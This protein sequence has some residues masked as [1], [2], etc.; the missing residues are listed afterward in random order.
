MS[1]L[2][3]LR[4]VLNMIIIQDFPRGEEKKRRGKVCGSHELVPS[5]PRKLE[6]A[7]GNHT[8]QGWQEAEMSL[9]SSPS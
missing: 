9:L 1:L 4:K 6:E 8:V 5:L 7:F 2:A 3:Y